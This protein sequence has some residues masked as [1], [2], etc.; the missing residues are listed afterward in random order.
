MS[1][2]GFAVASFAFFSLGALFVISSG[3]AR[4]RRVES[5]DPAS[6]PL[7][8]QEAK[9][10]LAQK[11]QNFSARG[12]LKD[13]RVIT[14]DILHRGAFALPTKVFLGILTFPFYLFTAPIFGVQEVLEVEFKD[15]WVWQRPFRRRYFLFL[16]LEESRAWKLGQAIVKLYGRTEKR[17]EREKKRN[18]EEV[19]EE[20]KLIKTKIQPEDS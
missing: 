12:E 8:A 9:S 2:C 11:G 19:K 18:R 16:P 17:K 15:G 7:T 4:V 10:L 1:R 13:L 14:F 3:C 20:R 5:L 6:V